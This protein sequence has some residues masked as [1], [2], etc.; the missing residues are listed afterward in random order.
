M[1]R[2]RTL[3]LIAVAL[4]AYG[5]YIAS[6]VP[7]ML[8][9]PSTPGLLIGFVLQ[10]VCALLAAFGIWRCER[11]AAGAAVSLGVS[12][13]GTWLFEAFVLGIV[14]YLG[15]LLVAVSALVMTL[16]IAAYLNR[17]TGTFKGLR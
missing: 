15:A 10:A 9:R 11:W 17:Q 1:N 14:A 7:A 4:A 12:I 2:S 13:A 8:V 3:L 16:L 5:L 6:Y